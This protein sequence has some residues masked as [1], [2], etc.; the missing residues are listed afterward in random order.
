MTKTEFIKAVAEKAEITQKD[1]KAIL[2]AT[3]EVLFDT[4]KKGDEVHP[5][6]GVTFVPFYREARVARN[7]STGETINVPGKYSVKAKLGKAI[8]DAAAEIQ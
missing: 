1:S 4:I 7:P 3:Q 8:K 2:A 6:D 5:F